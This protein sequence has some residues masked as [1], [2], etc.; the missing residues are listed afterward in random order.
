MF[1]WS[2]RVTRRSWD[3]PEW[4]MVVTRGV[5][6][7]WGIPVVKLLL[8][9]QVPLFRTYPPE[10]APMDTD[11]DNVHLKFQG[12]KMILRWSWMSDGCC[13]RGVTT[14]LSGIPVVKL[15]LL[16][17]VPLFRTY[18]PERAPM[19]TDT[20]NVYLKLQG[21]KLILRW[22]WMSDGCAQEG[23]GDYGT[24]SGIPVVKI[25]L[26][27][28]VPLSGT[29]PPERAPMDTD[30]DNDVYL[31][32]Q[33]DKMILRWSWQEGWGD[34]GTLSGIKIVKLLLL[35]WVP[36]FRTYP[37]ERAPMDTDTDNVY[38]KFQGDKMILRW[39][40]MSDGC[41]Q[42]GWGDYIIY[43]PCCAQHCM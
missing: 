5:T 43:D 15:L 8:F 30:T 39:S 6:T 41:A 9:F 10:R 37:P 35:F 40:W 38:L 23:W 17:W 36:L 13:T 2:F 21:D 16:F 22:S 28:W 11:T 3:D 29:Y 42:E 26:L 1:T 14:T 7:L 18:P 20:D 24:L 32:L 34:Y 19:D 27:F 25:L 12:D 4:V 31:K 33:G